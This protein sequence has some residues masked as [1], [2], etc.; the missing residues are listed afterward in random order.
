MLYLLKQRYRGNAPFLKVA[1]NYWLHDRK[2]VEGDY[3]DI[4]RRRCLGLASMG[5][6]W[7]KCRNDLLNYCLISF[8]LVTVTW[9]FWNYKIS[10]HNNKKL[11]IVDTLPR[12]NLLARHEQ[13]SSA[14][15][16]ILTYHNISI[17][18]SIWRQYI[19]WVAAEFVKNCRTSFSFKLC[20]KQ[21]PIYEMKKSCWE[22]EFEAS[23]MWTLG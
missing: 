13:S 11:L 12:C 23:R 15:Y 8:S 22:T 1:I 4:L 21:L 9:T 17:L 18:M 20:R 7:L 14:F 2:S 19:L 10:V 5:P 6:D 16:F 3:V